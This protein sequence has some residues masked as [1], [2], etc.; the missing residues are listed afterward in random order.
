VSR[1]GFGFDD[2]RR[3]LTE[4]LWGQR[5]SR[6]VVLSIA[7]GVSRLFLAAGLE[8][9]G[10]LRRSEEVVFW[11]DEGRACR[12]G[13]FSKFPISGWLF[14]WRWRKKKLPCHARRKEPEVSS[15]VQAFRRRPVSERALFVFEA[16]LPEETDLRVDLMTFGKFFPFP[17]AVVAQN[18]GRPFV[19]IRVRRLRASIPRKAFLGVTINGVEEAALRE[20][21]FCGE[22]LQAKRRGRAMATERK[23]HR[24]ARRPS[25]VRSFCGELDSASLRRARDR[26]GR[27]GFMC[28]RPFAE[29]GGRGAAGRPVA[30]PVSAKSLFGRAGPSWV[31]MNDGHAELRILEFAEKGPEMGFAVQNPPPPPRIAGG[32]VGGRIFGRLN[33]GRGRLRRRLLFAAGEFVLDDG[34]KAMGGGERRFEGFAKRRGRPRSDPTS[35]RRRGS[36]MVSSRVMRGRRFE[37]L[38]D[39]PEWCCSGSGPR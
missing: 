12:R 38:K 10:R 22:L 9:I 31:T 14:R 34:R 17:S 19:R 3:I 30:R 11:P 36:S 28:E 32:L 18:G 6:R 15:E 26:R 33:V 27:G 1:C 21:F 23:R 29:V 4:F 16:N 20:A 35:A 39:Q 7:D 8:V 2:A 25:V 24:P 5:K 13:P 37:G